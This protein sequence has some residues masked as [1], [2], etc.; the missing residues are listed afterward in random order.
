MTKI[1]VRFVYVTGL[2]TNLFH[3]AR[4]WGSWD[5]EGRYS[6]TWTEAPMQAARGE[7]GC[8][9]FTATFALDASQVNGRF[10]WGVR[11]DGPS[12]RGVWAIP[13]EVNDRLSDERTRSFALLP[14]ANGAGPQE[15]RYYLTH[16][17][18]LGA[19]KIIGPGNRPGLRGRP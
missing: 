5:M 11:V 3:N 8:L 17:R 6:E 7:D 9:C 19:Q 18:R 14:P 12:G 1:P 4:L 15:E 10:R 16:C 13:T 2:D